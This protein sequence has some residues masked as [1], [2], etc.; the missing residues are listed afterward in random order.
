MKI[1]KKT[2]GRSLLCS[3]IPTLSP[4][5]LVMTLDCSSLGKYKLSD[6]AVIFHLAATKSTCQPASALASLVSFRWVL[7]AISSLFSRLHLLGSPF[8][9]AS[10]ILTLYCSHWHTN[11]FYCLFMQPSIYCLNSLL[12]FIAKFLKECFMHTALHLLF[13]PPEF[14]FTPIFPLKFLLS[15]SSCFLSLAALDTINPSSFYD[16]KTSAYLPRYSF[17]VLLQ[18]PGLI[19]NW[20]VPVWLYQLLKYWNTSYQF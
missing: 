3:Q 6:K 16:T 18:D 5:L 12:S 4:G 19:F 2:L 14:G 7:D 1:H 9:S 13:N 15:R 20:S 10:P 11:I 17:W 8:D